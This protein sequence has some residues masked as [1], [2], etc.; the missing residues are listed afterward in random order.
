MRAGIKKLV[1]HKE[2]LRVVVDQE[3]SRVQGGISEVQPAFGPG[4]GC[5]WS[6]GAHWFQG[7][8]GVGNCFD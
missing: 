2:T 1:L 7:G 4:S 5:A 6:A 8:V 3:L